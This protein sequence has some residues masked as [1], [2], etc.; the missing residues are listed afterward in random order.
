MLRRRGQDLSDGDKNQE[1]PSVPLWREHQIRWTPKGV[2]KEDPAPDA[3][4]ALGILKQEEGWN[5]IWRQPQPP[6]FGIGAG[7]GIRQGYPPPPHQQNRQSGPT[8]TPAGWWWA[9]NQAVDG[10]E[11]QSTGV[12]ANLAAQTSFGEL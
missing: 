4:T 3:E 12:R 6:V 5:E 9:A 8:E 10:K 11:A 1:I 7:F 2:F